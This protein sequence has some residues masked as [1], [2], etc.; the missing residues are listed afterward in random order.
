MTTLAGAKQFK[1]APLM[2]V[3]VTKLVC[4]WQLFSFKPES[5][6]IIFDFWRQK[7]CLR[8]GGGDDDE[9]VLDRSGQSSAKLINATTCHTRTPAPEEQRSKH[10]QQKAPPIGVV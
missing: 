4:L 3:N 9:H 10:I 2:L 7:W 6:R 5:W 8:S 1:V